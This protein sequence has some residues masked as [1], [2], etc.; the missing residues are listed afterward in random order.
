MEESVYENLSLS[1]IASISGVDDVALGWVSNQILVLL[2]N[3]LVRAFVMVGLRWADSHCLLVDA[4]EENN[5][6]EGTQETEDEEH[7]DVCSFIDI[8]LEKNS[9]EEAHGGCRIEWRAWDD[10]DL[11]SIAINTWAVDANLREAHNGDVSSSN[12]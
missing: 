8:T 10:L 5:S 9:K 3:I 11:A 7:P 1:I 6:E 4:L 2:T 12:N